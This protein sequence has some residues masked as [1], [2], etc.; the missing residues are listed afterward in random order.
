MSNPHSYRPSVI[1]TGG[2]LVAD[3]LKPDG[4][5]RRIGACIRLAYYYPEALESLALR[6]LAQPFYDSNSVG[7]FVLRELYKARNP[8]ESRRLFDAYIRRHGEVSRD[9]ILLR[10]FDDLDTL[11]AHEEK[12]L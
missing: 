11:E 6:F 2:I 10:L 3:F 9:G 7:L 8:N 1:R 5:G 12:R 4:D